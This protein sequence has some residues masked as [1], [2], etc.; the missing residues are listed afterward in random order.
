M[1][2][3]LSISLLLFLPLMAR[4]QSFGA[5]STTEQLVFLLYGLIGCLGAVAITVFI[6][7]FVMYLVRLGT[8]QRDDGIKIMEWGVGLVIT[9]VVVIGVLRFVEWLTL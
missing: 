1:K 3:L 6:W 4:A 2:P 5:Y 9:V 7:G 8:V